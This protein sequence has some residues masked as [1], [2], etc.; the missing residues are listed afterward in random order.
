MYIFYMNVYINKYVHICIYIYM[1]IIWVGP[2]LFSNLNRGSSSSSLLLLH[3]Y[4]AT[5][6]EKRPNEIEALMMILT[7]T[8]CPLTILPL[9]RATLEWMVA[10]QRKNLR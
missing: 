2:L 10:V 7:S 8:R 5:F 9:R 4:F 1:Y 3:I 6:L